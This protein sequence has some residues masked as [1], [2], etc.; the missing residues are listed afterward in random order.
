MEEKRRQKEDL[1]RREREAEAAEDARLERERAELQRREDA[2]RGAKRGGGGG[3]ATIP[4]TPT[5]APPPLFVPPEKRVESPR[6]VPPADDWRGGGQKAT[7]L[8][9]PAETSQG[10]GFFRPKA[11]ELPPPSVAEDA[12]SFQTIAPR[13]IPPPF[14][15]AI[16]LDQRRNKRGGGRLDD[17]ER[18]E[19]LLRRQGEMIERLSDQLRQKDAT[20]TLPPEEKPSRRAV[21]VGS[22]T[23]DLTPPRKGAPERGFWAEVE[24]LVGCYAANGRCASPTAAPRR[25]EDVDV[26]GGVDVGGGDRF[27]QSLISMSEFVA[28]EKDDLA[29][30]LAGDARLIYDGDEWGAIGRGGLRQRTSPPVEAPLP[31]RTFEEA[32]RPALDVVQPLASSRS[33]AADQSERIR[34]LASLRLSPPDLPKRAVPKPKPPT[35]RSPLRPLAAESTFV[36]VGGEEESLPTPSPRTEG[37][38]EI[39]RTMALLDNSMHTPLI[40]NP[41]SRPRSVASSAA[42]SPRVVKPATPRTPPSQRVGRTLEDL[43]SVNATRLELL[44]AMERELMRAPGEQV[45]GVSVFSASQTDQ[46]VN[47]Y[48]EGIDEFRK[49]KSVQLREGR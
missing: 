8:F 16:E 49:R 40:L 34:P 20:P 31:T 5:G 47:A 6:A 4:R 13:N 39:F 43:F 46:V 38:A 45:R 19:L 33:D 37:A 44:S 12:S 26:A 22:S 1:R 28:E 14:Q 32:V 2:A 21:A 17:V 18:L 23:Q 24:E 29:R 7:D 42:P 48:L 30:S 9:A 41:S 35:P 36:A 10:R 11:Q 25:G 3:G 15:D 27:E